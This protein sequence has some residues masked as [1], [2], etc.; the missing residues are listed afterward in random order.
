MMQS[1]LREAETVIP[2]PDLARGYLR[3]KVPE[4]ETIAEITV[5]EL[6]YE[7]SS[8]LNPGHWTKIAESIHDNRDAFDG[9]VVL[10]G[11]DT[12]AY[13]A[14][15]L[16]FALRG[17]N[18]PV[19]FTGSQVPLTTLRSDARRNLVNSVEIATYDLPE[20]AICF[21]DRLYRGNRT[22]KMSIGDF[23]AFA[24]PNCPPLAEIGLNIT[25]S[26]HVL[27]GLNEIDYHSSFCPDIYVVKLF[28]GLNPNLLLPLLDSEVKAIIFEGFG[29]G[30]LPMNGQYSL[31]QFVN[32][33]SDR[34]IIMVM[35]SQAP[36]DAVDLNKYASGRE[37]QDAGVISGAEMTIE[38]CTTKLM[39]L[40]SRYEDT[41]N[42]RRL[43]NTNLAGEIGN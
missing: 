8:S 41:N 5:N 40:L 36:Y 15:A 42:I 2:N 18:K 33:C 43:L 9:F 12:M 10:H 37:A 11:T 39:Y 24:S 4:L 28:P 16:S 20:V 14:S 17:L 31:M 26:D 27:A 38:A 25:F 1:G 32:R 7:D 19:V 3:N 21:N 30:N 13:T 23:D 6:F 34:D 22:T 29:S 35:C